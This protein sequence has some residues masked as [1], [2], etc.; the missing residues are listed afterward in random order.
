MTYP[1]NLRSWYGIQVRGYLNKAYFIP[2]I[3]LL[4]YQFLVIK[5]HTDSLVARSLN[6]SPLNPSPLHPVH[7]CGCQ[8]T[9]HRGVNSWV[10]IYPSK[11]ADC[12]WRVAIRREQDCGFWEA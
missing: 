12:N 10:M 11:V 9:I 4:T 2:I 8:L 3:P 1:S 7:L 5:D 6:P